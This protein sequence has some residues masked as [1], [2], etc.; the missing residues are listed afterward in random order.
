MER[1][2]RQNFKKLKDMPPDRIEVTVDKQFTKDDFEK[3]KLGIRSYDMD[4]RWNILFEDN[5]LYM[6]RSWTGACIFIGQF[7]T[8][9][10]GT[11]HLLKLVVNG[12]LGQYKR[13][14]AQDDIE[15][16]LTII[17]THLIKRVWDK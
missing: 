10:D 12:D 6:Y 4:Q 11:G 5:L 1:L 8:C 13:V 2:I 15:I 7:D 3:I 16:V 14:N 17:D 9:N